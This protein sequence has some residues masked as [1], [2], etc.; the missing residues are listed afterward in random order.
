MSPTVDRVRA[1][2]NPAAPIDGLLL[3]MYGRRNNLS[4]LV[5]ADARTFFGKRVY[6]E[7]IPRSVRVSEAPSHG[8]PVILYDRRSAGAEAYVRVA[9]EFTQRLELDRV[10]VAG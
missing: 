3:T 8:K 6:R 10:G 4:E 1:V 9:R 7:A 5:A 2:L